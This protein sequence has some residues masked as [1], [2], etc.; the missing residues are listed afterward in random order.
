VE[1]DVVMEMNNLL[2]E[3][4]NKIVFPKNTTI[5]SLI[6]YDDISELWF[7]LTEKGRKEW[8]TIKL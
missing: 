1:N 7:E 4:K 8:E 5:E 6:S 2:G 3:E